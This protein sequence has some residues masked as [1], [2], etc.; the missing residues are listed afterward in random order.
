MLGLLYYFILIVDVLIVDVLWSLHFRKLVGED[1][2]VILSEKQDGAYAYVCTL[3]IHQEL[4]YWVLD[5]FSPLPRMLVSEQQLKP[6]KTK[7][8]M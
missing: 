1:S 3:C 6:I 2:Q 8:A 5:S 7:A 4:G